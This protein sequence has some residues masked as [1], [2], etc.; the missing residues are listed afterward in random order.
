[1]ASPSPAI[2]TSRRDESAG[3]EPASA[4][5]DDG[6]RSGSACMIAVAAVYL[7]CV[8][9]ATWP[10]FSTLSTHLP[11]LVDPLQ[12]LWVM[13][14]T[15]SCLL[16]G[17]APFFCPE[18]QYPVG[19]AL[20]NF[21]PLQLQSLLYILISSVTSNDVLTYN[22]IWTFGF[23]FT[24]L[25]V[26]V[27]VG[28]V[29]RDRFS[30]AFGGMLAMLATPM[31]IHARG[32]LELIHLGSIAFFLAA[33]MRFVA[34]PTR[35]RL[36]IAVATYWLVAASAAY[37]MIL[38]AI[39]ATL[40][41]LWKLAAA[42]R[43]RRA[44]TWLRPRLAW[45]AAFVGLALPGLL[46]LFANQLWGVAHGFSIARGRGEFNAYGAPLW[47]YATP[48]ILHAS[49]TLLPFNPYDACGFGASV[50]E[51]GS[52][53]GIVTLLLMNYAVMRRVRFHGSSFWWLALGSAV[54]LSMGAHAWVGTRRVELPAA[55]L[56]NILPP[57]RLIRV[58]ARFNLVATIFA[59][60]IAA[61]ALKHWMASISSRRRRIALALGLSALA[62]VD[63]ANVPFG[64]HLEVPAMSAAYAYIHARRP[65]AALLEMPLFA[66]SNS[67]TVSAVSGYWQSLHGMKTSTGYSGV[68]NR[69]FDDEV[70]AGSPFTLA[71]LHI[72]PET[73]GGITPTARNVVDSSNLAAYTWL[74]MKVHKFDYVVVHRWAGA[75]VPTALADAVVFDDGAA[76]VIDRERLPTPTMPVVLAVRGWIAR[77]SRPDGCGHVV[78]R[79]ASMIVFNPDDDAS[80]RIDLD[81]VALPSARRLSLRRGDAVL[82]SWR[83]EPGFHRSYPSP[84]FRLPAGIHD[85]TLSSKAVAMPVQQAAGKV[86]RNKIALCVAS[87][88]I[89]VDAPRTARAADSESKPKPIKK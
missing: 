19:A 7:A 37:Y 86:E 9:V 27:L 67:Q 51:R 68:P 42:L 29:T 70:A 69:R 79:D 32:H 6:F 56:W 82:A 85:L 61:A 81:A 3:G 84:A 52:Y 35:G 4:D 21:S 17:R 80:L 2:I 24:G 36:L 31:M 46:L 58:P 28:Q 75:S 30:A 57:F 8:A 53:L 45:S 76:A 16:A 25:G 59:A 15:K 72:P 88:R 23:V 66:S 63:L 89:A 65:A 1:M 10:S 13:R 39:P 47:S 43:Q 44:W 78:V 20:G 60:V 5:A 49:S 71:A 14:W 48:T 54:V 73:A 18:L 41:A 26:F 33:W 34:R 87:L 55:W 62:L 22:L 83:V 50:V 12:H 77:D 11:S 64:E 38:A 74:Y 40:Y